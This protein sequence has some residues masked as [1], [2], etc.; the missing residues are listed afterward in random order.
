[1]PSMDQEQVYDQGTFFFNNGS[2]TSALALFSKVLEADP[3]LDKAWNAKGVTY[4][5]MGRYDEALKCYEKALMIRPGDSKYLDNREKSLLKQ[6][7]DRFYQ[8][9]VKY[10]INTEDS[11]PGPA[12]PLSQGQGGPVLIGPYRVNVPITALCLAF[13][14]VLFL[15]HTLVTDGQGWFPLVLLGIAT[16]GALLAYRDA[17]MLSSGKNPAAAGLERWRPESWGWFLFI[18]FPVSSLVYL[19]RRKTIF[20][21]NRKSRDLPCLPMTPGQVLVKGLGVLV[22]LACGIMVIISFIPAITSL[23]P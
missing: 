1:M 20:I 8:V 10:T 12:T 16:T 11:D 13:W 15:S 19:A 23:F 18:L 7:A 9:P 17:G 3:S 6:R 2:Y 21:T 22:M 4:A 5:K 14:T